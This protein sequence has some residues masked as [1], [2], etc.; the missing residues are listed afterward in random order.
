MLKSN[1]LRAASLAE[2][3]CN[4]GL[5]DTH[6]HIGPE[7]L[8]RRYDVAALAEAAACC[9]A[10]VVLKNHTYSTA[11]LA[12][13]ARA[14]FGARL[15]GSIVLNRFVGGLNPDAILGALSGNR[16]DVTAIGP[17]ASDPPLVVWMPTVHAVAHL[18]TLGRAFDP[19]WHGGCGAGLEGGAEVPVEVFD[20]ALRPRPELLAVLDLLTR[21]GCRLATGHLSAAEIMRL[22]PLAL[23][24]GVPGILITHP[25][26]P[27][28]G[29]SDEQL[30]Q[31][32]RD[33]RVF[34][35]HCFAIH[36]IEGIPLERIAA[37]IRITGPDQVVVASDFG[38]ICSDPFPDGTIRYAPLLEDL[39]GNAMGRADFLRLFRDNGAIALG[40]QA[41]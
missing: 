41:R 9:N 19:R 25:H 16:A 37:S 33:S 22:V 21:T 23:E 11:P 39:L 6:Y 20:A 2:A 4:G 40:L 31:L 14:R 35:E 1:S 36:S 29:L 7:L 13:L 10:T 32:T 5:V 3:L 34:V 30:Y 17:P 24:V 26:Y 15:V 18:R 27:S 28:V 12:S 38:Q 8:P